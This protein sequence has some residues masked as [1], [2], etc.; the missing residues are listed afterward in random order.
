VHAEVTQGLALS[1][2]AVAPRPEARARL[3][4][5]IT[6]PPTP[7]PGFAFVE[8]PDGVW[9][10]IQPGVFQKVLAT[11]ASAAPTAYLIRLKAGAHVATHHHGIVEHCYVVEGDL[12]IAGRDIEAGDYHVADPGTTHDDAWTRDGC[13]LLIVES[14]V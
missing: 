13:L 5:A 4:A 12:H 11:S 14:R 10:E 9:N 6:R 2:V 1:P 3:L 7:G 8:D